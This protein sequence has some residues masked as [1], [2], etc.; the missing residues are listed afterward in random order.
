[1]KRFFHNELEDL[2]G[3]ILLMGERAL[4]QVGLAFS[5]LE[6]RDVTK[7]EAVLKQ[8]DRIDELEMEI[9]N[10]VIRYISLRAPVATELRLLTTSMKVAHDLERVGDEACTIV[11]RARDLIEEERSLPLLEL[12]RMNRLAMRLLRDAMDAF[13]NEDFAKATE[14]PR[15][16]KE[17]DDINRG[18]FRDYQRLVQ[19]DGLSVE[20]AFSLVFISKALERIGD[21]ATNL[22][23]AVV[24]MYRGEDIRHSDLTK[25]T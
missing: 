25:R 17:I 13:L 11:K 2:R 6:E 1:M 15:H 23:E 20:T 9:D 24:F 3:R 5:A 8:D 12:A 21:H 18:H 10:E 7:I 16:D 4:D 19:E 14:L 22:A